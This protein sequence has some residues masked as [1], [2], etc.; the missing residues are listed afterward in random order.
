MGK[1]KLDNLFQEKFKDFSHIPDN[2]VWR[3]IDASLEQ[4]KKSR[5]IIP[6]WWKFGGVAAVL[7]IAL[8]LINPFEGTTSNSTITNVN[9]ATEKTSE[10]IKEKQDSEHLSI[11]PASNE[12]PIVNSGQDIQ[13][14]KEQDT[15]ASRE[16]LVT[17]TNATIDHSNSANTDSNRVILKN[18]KTNAVQVTTTVIQNGQKENAIA[19]V[20]THEA[21][22]L[23]KSDAA[24]LITSAKAKKKQPLLTKANTK[25]IAKDSNE[26]N[27][28]KGIAQLKEEDTS[29]ALED[30]KKK[31][32][33]DEIAK[34]EEEKEAIVENTQSK[35]SAG[36]SIAPVYFNA[37]GEGSPIHSIF[38][39]NSKSGSITLSYGLSVAYDY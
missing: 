35:W 12:A 4:K 14:A 36:P 19:A 22:T 28:T 24:M 32:I 31:S 13:K 7:A 38:V 27:K 3:S 18:T 34:Q 29:R 30:S 9:P 1:K 8:F 17:T 39:P 5:K 2:K 25:E 20:S 6:I 26:N 11:T 10:E 23:V 16:Q 37:A 33:F 15:D 21:N